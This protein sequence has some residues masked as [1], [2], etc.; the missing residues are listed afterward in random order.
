MG[1]LRIRSGWRW[2][3]L[4]FAVLVL[5]I[6]VL[7]PAASIPVVKLGKAGR[8]RLAAADHRSAAYDDC[9][10]VASPSLC[11]DNCHLTPILDVCKAMCGCKRPAAARQEGL[12]TQDGALPAQ[13][14]PSPQRAVFWP[15]AAGPGGPSAPSKPLLPSKP[16]G[17]S[18]SSGCGA[19]L[20]PPS[21]FRIDLNEAR[22]GYGLERAVMDEQYVSM[23]SYIEG[24]QRAAGCGQG[25]VQIQMGAGG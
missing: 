6:A 15:R 16:P 10:D 14:Y 5:L 19:R 1:A 17:L 21:S 3:P 7:P 4:L 22:V 11:A 9:H 18:N 20:A 24:R 8:T 25:V 23:V 2:A 13:Q 12:P